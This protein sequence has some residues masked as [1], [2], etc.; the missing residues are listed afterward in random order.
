MKVKVKSAYELSGSSGRSVSGFCSMTR[1]GVFLLLP[2]W[3][4]NPTQGYPSIKF[5]GTQLYTWVE[6]GTVGIKYLAQEHN[7]M[8]PTRT[9]L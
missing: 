5:A 2:G 3:D 4:A 9:S 1:P 8:A 6:R 7:T